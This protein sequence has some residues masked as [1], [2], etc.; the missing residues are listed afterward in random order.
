M[1]KYVNLGGAQ[2]VILVG[3]MAMHGRRSA[4]PI[5]MGGGMALTFIYL[6]Y[7]HARSTG[8]ANGQATPKGFGG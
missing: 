3:I 4:G 7:R 8:L 5:L 6:M 2:A 1:W